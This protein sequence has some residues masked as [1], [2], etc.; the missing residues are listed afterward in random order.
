MRIG[1]VTQPLL[2]NY[3]GYLQNYALQQVLRQ[4]GHIPITIDVGNRI[5]IFRFVISTIRSIIFYFHPKKRRHFADFQ[6]TR[7]N[8][9][10]EIFTA[11]LGANITKTEDFSRYRS[12]YVKRYAF[13]AVITGS[14][15]VWRPKYNKYLED[16]YLR[17]VCQKRVLKIAYA[18]SFGTDKW[19]YTE[20]QERRCRIYA[21]RLDAISM[22]EQSGVRLCKEHFEVDAV[23]VLD[24]TLLLEVH[25][26]ELLCKDVPKRVPFIGAYI[27]DVADDLRNQL[28]IM[29]RASALDV[30]IIEADAQSSITVEEWVSTYRDA[31]CIITNSFHGTVFSIIFNKPFVCLGNK[32]RGNDRF[33]SLLESLGLGGRMIEDITLIDDIMLQPIDWKHVNSILEEYRKMSKMFLFKALDGCS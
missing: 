4:M 13:D 6:Q 9:R 2:A 28:E 7:Y 1:I 25:D 17:F 14:D 11:F 21:R 10:K 23:S 31:E 8:I 29:T 3:G 5:S 27:L 15:Q 26:Y 22:R 30:K 33:N 19:E 12:C 16:M 18:A 32:D 24:P 20:A